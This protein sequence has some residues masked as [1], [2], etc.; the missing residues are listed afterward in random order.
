VEHLARLL[1]AVFEEQF[2][3][4]GYGVLEWTAH[5][6]A[7]RYSTVHAPGCLLMDFIRRERQVQFGKVRYA[8]FNRPMPNFLPLIF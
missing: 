8:L 3:E 5:A 7:K 1:P 2:I 6:V 4:I